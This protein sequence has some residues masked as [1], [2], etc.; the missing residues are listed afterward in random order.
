M[1]QLGDIVSLVHYNL[2]INN[3]ANAFCVEC[4]KLMEATNY[5]EKAFP[6]NSDD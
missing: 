2:V 3:S 1:G 4:K 5:F 6:G